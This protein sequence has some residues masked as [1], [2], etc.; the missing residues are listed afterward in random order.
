MTRHTRQNALGLKHEVARLSKVQFSDQSG[1]VSAS[2][3]EPL[4]LLADLLSP[5]LSPHHHVRISWMAVTELFHEVLSDL[6]SVL[7]S[8][9][10]ELTSCIIQADHTL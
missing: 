4:L 5:H 6:E 9:E 8:V 2:S 10:I 7:G 3:L 1:P